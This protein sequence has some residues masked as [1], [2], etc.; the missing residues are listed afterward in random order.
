MPAIGGTSLQSWRFLAAFLLVLLVSVVPRGF[1]VDS[2]D[3]SPPGMWPADNPD[4]QQG[5]EKN[6][7]HPVVWTNDFHI[8]T[9]GNVKKLLEP[10]GVKFIDKSLS[11][12]CHMTKTCAK[13]LK[14]LNRGNGITPN[15]AIRKEFQQVYASDPEFAQ[16]DVVMCFHPSAMCELFMPLGKRLFVIAT[17][18]YEMGRHQKS[19]WEEWNKNLLEIAADKNNVV[20]ANNPYDQHYIEYFT[21]IRPLLLPSVIRMPDS[22]TGESSDILVTAMH[23]NRPP[24]WAQLNAV[25]SRL[26]SL[27]RK[28]GHY[29]YKQLCENT[30]ILHIP[31]QLSVMSLFEHYAMGIPILVPSPKFLWELHDAY[32]VVTERTW[33]RV[34][35]STRPTGSIIPGFKTSD[36]VP[37][38]NDDRS[39]EAFL[40]WAQYG[41]YYTL[42]HIVQFDSWDH[43]RD[44]LEK[45]GPTD[46]RAVSEKM[47]ASNAK[48]LEQVTEKWKTLLRMQ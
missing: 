47:L 36:S 32:D 16:V 13:D 17:T 30:A 37:D 39:E 45:Y 44:I 6:A 34:H 7:L 46:W 2:C 12:H 11:G 10:I 9:I 43:L 20:A 3:G 29:S 24:I 15:P 4:T 27:R 35:T 31:Y 41:D 23:P 40:H 21:G 38:P 42:P 26:V 18:R 19:E 48:L 22:Y 1:A 25:S 8:S 28:Y 14:V 5:G 33:T